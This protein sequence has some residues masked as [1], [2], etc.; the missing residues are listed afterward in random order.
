MWERRRRTFR[1]RSS[2]VIQVAGNVM[3]QV[4]TIKGAEQRYTSTFTVSGSNVTTMDTCPAPK[5]A[6]HRFSATA[7]NIRIIDSSAVGSVEQT[8]TKR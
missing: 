6:T 3:Q 7:T 8:Y 2:D 4:G 5:S 1:N